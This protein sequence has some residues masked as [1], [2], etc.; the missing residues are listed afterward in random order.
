MEE[1]A[2]SV[3]S[4]ISDFES[5]SED[6]SDNSFQVGKSHTLIEELRKE[7]V[8]CSLC[9]ELVWI[10]ES[11]YRCIKCKQFIIHK[12]NKEKINK[13]K[14]KFTYFP[15]IFRI[16]NVWFL[17]IVHLKKVKKKFSQKLD[18]AI[19]VLQVLTK[20]KLYQVTT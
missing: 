11:S 17:Q 6:E 1:R 8:T 16:V 19:T 18:L 10:T 5:K 13:R 12:V 20:R 15:F 4:I 9:S 14:K 2:N 3:S 7:T